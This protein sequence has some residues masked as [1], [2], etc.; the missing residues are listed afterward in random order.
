MMHTNKNVVSCGGFWTSFVGAAAGRLAALTL[1]LI[2]GPVAVLGQATQPASAAGLPAATP[3]EPRKH[4]PPAPEPR[5]EPRPERMETDRPDFTESKSAVAPGRVQLELGYTLIHDRDGSR[6]A[7]RHVGPESL[8]RIGLLEH[9][10]L[11]LGWGGYVLGEERGPGGGGAG[12]RRAA[13]NQVD[14]ATDVSIGIKQELWP[15]DAWRPAF[16]LLGELS[17]PSG[18]PGVSSGDVDPAIKLLCSWE[19]AQRFSLGGNLN[20]AVPTAEQGRFFETSASLALGW[21]A[22]EWLGVFVEYFG[23]FPHDRGADCAHYVNGGFTFPLTENTQFDVR[24]G[25][26][27]NEAADDFFAGVGFAV[28]F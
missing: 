25:A 1:G 26:G 10:E 4:P 21:E 28:R 9:T 15:Q 6:G 14:G 16:S 24:V 8:L 23:I 13:G 22:A 7:R 20:F 12:R 17:L 18:S 2:A 11:R 3:A 5:Q 19:L 27:L